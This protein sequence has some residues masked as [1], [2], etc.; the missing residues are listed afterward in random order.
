MS[1]VSN[2]SLH[3]FNILY[4]Q[5]SSDSLYIEVC[6]VTYLPNG[7]MDHLEKK[8]EFGVVDQATIQ[9][10]YCVILC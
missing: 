6:D 8:W 7:A 1:P 3:S 5:L 10:L 4:L 9:L 2:I